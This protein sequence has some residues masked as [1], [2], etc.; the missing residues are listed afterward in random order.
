[1]IPEVDLK[2]LCKDCASGNSNITKRV[3]EENMESHLLP[4]HVNK[5]ILCSHF[6]N[7]D[8]FP[9]VTKR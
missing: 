5:F 1:V 7:E 6:I 9:S 8:M 2:D 3:A 4:F